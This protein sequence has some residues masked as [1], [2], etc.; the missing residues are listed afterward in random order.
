[1]IFKYYLGELQLQRVKH[2]DDFTFTLL[3]ILT[4]REMPTYSVLLHCRHK[5]VITKLVTLHTQK[6]LLGFHHTF[7]KII[8]SNKSYRA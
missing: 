6:L 3:H 2:S 7:K 4:E 8:F 5:Y 1:V